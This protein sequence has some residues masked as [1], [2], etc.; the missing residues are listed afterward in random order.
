LRSWLSRPRVWRMIDFTIA[1]V[2]F[3]LA[4]KLVIG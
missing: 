4:A 2:M 3:V 1:A